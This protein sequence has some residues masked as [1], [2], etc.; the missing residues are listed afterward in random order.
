MNKGK[1][2]KRTGSLIPFFFTLRIS[3]LNIHWK[4]WCCSWSPT[5]LATWCKEP[6]H[7]K[8]PWCWKRLRAK[9]KGGGRGWDNQIASPTQW[10]WIWANSRR[11]WRTEKPGVLQP[12]GSQRVGH[13]SVTEQQQQEPKLSNT[14]YSRRDLISLATDFRDLPQFKDS[15]VH[16]LHSSCNHCLPGSSWTP[17]SPRERSHAWVERGSV[18]LFCGR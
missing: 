5:T 10:T 3:T 2:K 13:N 4:D 18:C 1:N 14:F 6:T 15:L 12:M 17:H 11:Q 16:V 9:G 8:R 7:W